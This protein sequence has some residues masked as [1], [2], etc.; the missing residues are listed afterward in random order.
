MMDYDPLNRAIDQATRPY[1]TYPDASHFEAIKEGYIKEN[2]A[3]RWTAA[4]VK[5]VFGTSSA[6]KNAFAKGSEA[7]RKAD[8]Q[9]KANLKSIQRYGRGERNPQ[10]APAGVQEKLAEVGQKLEPVK[11]D[12]PP[13]GLSFVVKFKD[14]GD[15][16]HSP[17]T[18]KAE[19]HLDHAT[20]VQYVTQSQPDYAF[21]F[22]QWFKGGGGAYGEGG[23][24]EVDVTEVT[25]A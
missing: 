15:K 21:L 18:R 24:Y 7:Y 14:P 4:L 2:G 10:H 22:D 9:Y 3:K 23:D 20:A 16:A 13:T 5:D 19:V 12:A 25:A 6:D 1:N 17:R 11:R 8:L